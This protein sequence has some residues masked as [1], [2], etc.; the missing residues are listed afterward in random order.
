MFDVLL[1]IGILL[2]LSIS[3]LLSWLWRSS[4]RRPWRFFAIGCVGLYLLMGYVFT[5]VLGR[6]GI[7]GV[8]PGP[9]PMFGPAETMF[10]LLLIAF[11]LVGLLALWCLKLVLAK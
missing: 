10:L 2:P 11:V 8:S 7:T 9:Q 1:L 6:V 3:A 5:R 4:L